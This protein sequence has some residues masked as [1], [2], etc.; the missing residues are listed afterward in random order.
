MRFLP[1]RLSI[2]F[3][4]F[5]ILI[6]ASE[7]KVDFVKNRPE[8]LIK[9]SL[10]AD[11]NKCK[12]ERDTLN[13]A[14]TY[15]LLGIKSFYIGEYTESI[16]HLRT[17]QNY[18]KIL[19]D[20]KGQINVES[21]MASI[22]GN[23]GHHEKSH[24]KLAEVLRLSQ[25]LQDT[26]LI[27]KA[28]HNIG[29]AHMYAGNY[30]SALFFTRNAIEYGLLVEGRR[31][32]YSYENLAT[33]F[34]KI[35]EYDSSKLYLD[36]ALEIKQALNVVP[37][38]LG[39][40]YYLYGELYFAQD[41][42][43]QAITYY[44]KS[45]SQFDNSHQAPDR[46]V[47]L[48]LGKCYSATGQYEKA[49]ANYE[50]YLT[51]KEHENL[52]NDPLQIENELVLYQIQRDSLER[53]RILL[54]N[55]LESTQYI[56]KQ[57]S[58]QSI[59]SQLYFTVVILSLLVLMLGLL[60]ISFRKRL[61]QTREHRTILALQNEELKRTLV[62]KEEK[63]TLLKE[64]HH[65]VKNN[66]QIISSLVR[67]QSGYINKNNYKE[68]LN[69]IENRIS[70]MALV[71]E[72]LYQSNDLSKLQVKT[73]IRDLSINILESY[74]T[75]IKVRFVFNIAPVEF[76]IDTLIPLGLILNEV[77]SNALKHGFVGRENGMIEVTLKNENERTL[78]ILKD[79]GIGADLSIDDL[80]ED[81]LGMD[82][83]LSLTEQLDGSLKIET[84][85]GFAYHFTF[86]ELA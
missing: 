25:K 2:L 37:E 52:R 5:P 31:E 69:E 86:P 17:A 3:A 47:F 10:L 16:K 7:R 62:S 8:E 29:T 58:D 30:D 33:I 21:N 32:H 67:L 64:I 83:I 24:Q 84:N 82:L 48:N 77:I 46:I 54:K 4:L 76:S 63:E 85:D 14:D 27:F 9:D 40:N 81:S 72:K 60:F 26:A 12:K 44:E 15:Y 22:F 13:V 59:R 18:Y 19:G 1:Y 20:L 42:L 61:K 23:L 35:E 34:M 39:K 55:E 74:Q 43:S 45:K 38:A 50:A 68:R 57:L 6:F 49:V 75:K 51:L 28:Y 11:L 80:K 36:K 73:Y 66:L 78:I 65:R 41:Q 53:E 56:N 79:N 71:H 70:S